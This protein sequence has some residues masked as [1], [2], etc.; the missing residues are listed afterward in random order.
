IGYDPSGNGDILSITRLSGT[1]NA[2]VLSFTY[3]PTYHQ[4]KTAAEPGLPVTTLA[5]DASANLTS[6]TDPTGIVTR[7]QLN[8]RGQLES[9][10]D[11]L[12]HTTTFTYDGGDIVAV[13]DPLGNTTTR[14]IDAAGRVRAVRDPYSLATRLL[15]H[16]FNR[17]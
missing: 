9:I 5:Y 15:Y 7:V 17:I 16:D 1:S 11:V 6:I 8:A 4:L 12:N 13:T 10:T 14:L 2:K 3:E